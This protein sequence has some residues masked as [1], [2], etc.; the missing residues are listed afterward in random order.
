MPSP[1][2][3]P[4]P[5]RQPRPAALRE[6]TPT[7]CPGPVPGPSPREPSDIHDPSFR[8]TSR[9]PSHGGHLSGSRTL[10][11]GPPF[12]RGC[13]LCFG[14]HQTNV[15]KAGFAHQRP[16]AGLSPPSPGAP[17]ARREGLAPGVVLRPSGVLGGHLH[18]GLLG[19]RGARIIA[20]RRD[21]AMRVLTRPAHRGMWP[22]ARQQGHPTQGRQSPR[23]RLRGGQGLC[24]AS[25]GHW[26]PGTASVV[27]PPAARPPGTPHFQVPRTDPLKRG[28]RSECRWRACQEP[29]VPDRCL[30]NA[31]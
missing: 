22:G 11:K 12:S 17:R 4:S 31:G 6:A 29:F 25:R 24:W 27:G 16:R 19:T 7:A 21:G 8:N 2:T 13:A 18:D 9:H 3:G 20:Q 26:S 28:T 15:T 5:D 10:G 23:L 14:R 1:S 30:E